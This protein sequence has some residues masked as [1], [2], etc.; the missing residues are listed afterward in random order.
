MIAVALWGHS[1]RG[2]C[3]TCYCDNQMVVAVMKSRS[4]RDKHLMHLLRCLF[5][6]EA[7]GQFKLRCSHIPGS[8]N[9]R[10]DDLSRDNLSA[11]FL[12]VPTANKSAAAFP[13]RKASML[14][15]GVSGETRAYQTIKTYTSAM[16][17]TC[18]SASVFWIY[19]TAPLFRY[20]DAYR[21]G[22]K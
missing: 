3:I 9:G 4:S 10:A 11:F 2:S 19:A 8:D 15:C 1:W 21:L 14:L 6:Y 5:F 17:A 22:S 16:R 18:T 7:C 13:V 20:W 12:K